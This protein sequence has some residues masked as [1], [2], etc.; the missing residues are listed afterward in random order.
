V[1]LLEYRRCGNGWNKTVI[2]VRSPL[3]VSFFGGGTDHPSWFNRPEPGAVL[4][5]TI[6]KYIYVQLRRLPAVFDFNYRIA[7]GILEEVKTISE[8]RHPVV[9]EVLKRHASQDDS[10]YEV[11]Y[12][13]DLPSKTGLGSSS[14]FT[15]SLLHAFFGNLERLCSKAF[16]AREAIFVEQQLLKETVGCQDQIATAYGGLNRID[17]A[18]GGEHRVRPLQVQSAR[19]H[20]LERRLMMFF[21]GFTRSAESVEQRKVVRFDQRTAQ[22]RAMYE[23]VNEGERILLD[24]SRSLSEFGALLHEAWMEKRKLDDCV[25]TAFIDETY[26]T[27]RKAGAVGGKLLGAGGGGFLLLFVLPERQDDVRAAL[28][29]LTYVPFCMER[30]GTS[31]VLYNPELTSNYLPA[32]A[33]VF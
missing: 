7:W 1:G 23:M 15:V 18:A 10:G 32:A 2:I 24:P 5:T 27:A 11:I 20:E 6:N 33:G 12:N 13:A 28:A 17:F 30:D 4:S 19:R 9:R 22:L 29:H 25:S 3:R 8:I 16:L 14:A 21:T 26:E 31:I